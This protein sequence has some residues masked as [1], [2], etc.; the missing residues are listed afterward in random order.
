M[1]T[2]R[3]L[4]EAGQPEIGFNENADWP[5]SEL[6]RNS[7]KDRLQRLTA[8]AR[9]ILDAAAVI[10]SGF[11]FEIIQQTAGRKEIETLDGLDELVSRHILQE[12]GNSFRFVHEIIRKTVYQDLSY[13]R[14]RLLHRRAG[15]A[16]KSSQP[17]NMAA[18][19]DHFERAEQPGQAAWYA[20]QAGMAARDIFAH[21]EASAYFNHALKLLDDETRNLHNPQ[22]ITENWSRRIQVLEG[23]GWILRLLGDMAAYESDL[24]EVARLAYLL[25]DQTTV[26]HLRWREA[27]SHRWFCRYQ[28]A[29]HAAQEGVLLS[30][31]SG[32]ALM[33]ARCLREDGLAARE[34][35]EYTQA[36]TLLEQALKT[37]VELDD[38]IFAIHA[39]GNLSRLH[40][41]Q[42]DFD[43]ASQYASQAMNFCQVSGQS[44]QRRIPLGDMGAALMGSA[45][46][47]GARRNLQESLDIS[48]QIDDRT[49]EIFC[50]GHLGWI[51][52]KEE[53][54]QQAE[55]YLNAALNLARTIG[56]VAEQSW[57]LAGIAETDLLNREPHK[58]L[59]HAHRARAL[60]RSVGRT[61]DETVANKI[62]SRLN[63]SDL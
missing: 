14:K 32:S 58:A 22:A 57:L 53:Q 47:P 26:A 39:M 23:R 12:E 56:S 46:L 30:Q 15:E 51:C 28:Q 54:P 11:K 34:L 21:T 50:L 25:G 49:Q 36:G 9:Q 63:N 24:R 20:L 1:E 60:A 35:G 45:D 3:A 33:R 13:W 6:V 55:S 41:Y 18:L 48:R 52:L 44:L 59:Q 29:R 16:I 27:V 10:G 31:A 4:V 5:V 37:F 40:W 7:V 42:H 38:V 61:Y 62:I 19:V 8:I 17:D 43:R 2:I